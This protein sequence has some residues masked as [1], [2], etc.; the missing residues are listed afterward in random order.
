MCHSSCVE[1]G[2]GALNFVQFVH[3]WLRILD[4]IQDKRLLRFCTVEF[5]MIVNLGLPEN[6]SF[7]IVA[8]YFSTAPCMLEVL[9]SPFSALSEAFD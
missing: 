2:R 1:F 3:P 8:V 7:F 9:V 6:S 4:V 5:G